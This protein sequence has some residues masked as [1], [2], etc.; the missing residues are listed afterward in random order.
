MD[1]IDII[2]TR[3][4]DGR[5]NKHVDLGPNRFMSNLYVSVLN[6]LT[7]LLVTNKNMKSQK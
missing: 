7:L 4:I 6:I 2:A 1:C 3:N 5:L